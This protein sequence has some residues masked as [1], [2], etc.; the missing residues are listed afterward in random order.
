MQ[1]N[2]L[3][4]GESIADD[5]D[6]CPHCGA[7]SHY[8]KRGFRIGGREKFLIFFVVLSAATLIMALL[9]PR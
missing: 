3:Y 7:P 5:I 9:L 6:H 8:Q 1:V 2:C 4:C